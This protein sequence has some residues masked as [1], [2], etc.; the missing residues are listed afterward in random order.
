ML[1]YVFRDALS[2][3]TVVGAAIVKSAIGVQLRRVFPL[4]TDRR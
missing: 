4:Q 1:K 3:A 2:Y